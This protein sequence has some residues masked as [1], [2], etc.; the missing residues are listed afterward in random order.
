MTNQ[1]WISLICYKSVTPSL[2]AMKC[3]F[4]SLKSNILQLL[5]A[6]FV[7]RLPSQQLS[8][9]FFGR[10]TTCL[11]SNLI[12]FSSHQRSSSGGPSDKKSGGIWVGNF[13]RGFQKHLFVMWCVCVYV[14]FLGGTFAMFFEFMNVYECSLLMIV[15][16]YFSKKFGSEP[17]RWHP[18]YPTWQAGRIQLWR[19]MPGASC[20]LWQSDA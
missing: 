1:I 4:R 8:G 17:P 10:T 20:W 15:S 16:H 12:I 3:C 18:W 6:A 2:L 19:N 13:H 11:D 9:V 5:S 14:F 7:A